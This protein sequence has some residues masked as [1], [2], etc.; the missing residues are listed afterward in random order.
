MAA[1]NA[2]D[3]S[4]NDCIN[5]GMDASDVRAL[6]DNATAVGT[7]G[8]VGA[9]AFNAD[10][11]EMIVN[12]GQDTLG[13]PTGLSSL[14]SIIRGLRDE[15]IMVT[16]HTGDGKSTFMHW[17]LEQQAIKGTPILIGSFENGPRAVA[18]DMFQRHYGEPIT[19]VKTDVQAANAVRAVGELG[20]W[21]VYI[22]NHKGPIGMQALVEQI[23]YARQHLGVKHVL[24]DHLRFI[25]PRERT[26]DQFEGASQTLMEFSALPQSLGCSITMVAHPK[27]G[28]ERDTVPTGDS[29]FGGG[30]AKQ[31][32]D[33]GISVYRDP[34]P[35]YR[36]KE[37]R[38][39]KVRTPTGKQE[40]ELAANETL[41]TVW[42][43][44]S[45]AAQ[46]GQAVV[47][48]D[49]PSL[50]FSDRPAPVDSS[51]PAENEGTAPPLFDVETYV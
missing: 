13:T 29:I 24:L 33:T 10:L 47:Q 37:P 40:V 39:F 4:P 44:R 1:R 34:E 9:S 48:F 17:L 43:S 51:A 23:T 27:H 14:D 38:R 22:L 50:R 5:A 41:I 35:N 49:R 12:R 36:S 11:L 6:I 45:K 7:S 20:S 25:K 15:F 32:C 46:R 28:V 8:I 16:G 19:N 42:K 26:R 21:P 18:M 30:D 3:V 31:L 2:E